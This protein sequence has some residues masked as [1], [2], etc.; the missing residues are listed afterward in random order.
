MITGAKKQK[1][2]LICFLHGTIV[3]VS[4]TAHDYY[5]FRGRLRS[6]V[7]YLLAT[8]KIT[9]G[10]YCIY[11][12]ISK[13]VFSYR[14]STVVRRL[15]WYDIVRCWLMTWF[16]CYWTHHR[17]TSYTTQ[18]TYTLE[19]TVVTDAH[20]HAVGH[21]QFAQCTVGL[22]TGWQVSQEA[23]PSWPNSQ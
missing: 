4:L 2:W 22:T 11:L 8:V 20:I 15:P 1:Y 7:C 13:H 19:H 23:R 12:P 18:S 21:T 17:R 16:D 6:R 3:L 14:H 5:Y 10:K 9:R